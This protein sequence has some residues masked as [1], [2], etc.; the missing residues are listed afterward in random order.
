MWQD[1]LGLAHKYIQEKIVFD[2][3]FERIF[4]YN[5]TVKL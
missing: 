3:Y 2:D 5:Y 1:I 4:F